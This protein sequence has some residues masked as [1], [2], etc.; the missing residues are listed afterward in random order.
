M[1]KPLPPPDIDSEPWHA[2]S[3]EQLYDRRQTGQ[4]GLTIAEAETR[5]TRYGRDELPQPQPASV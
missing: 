5:Q 2:L 3:V 4:A 1:Q